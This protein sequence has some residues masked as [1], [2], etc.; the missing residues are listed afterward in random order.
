MESRDLEITN[1]P[2]TKILAVTTVTDIGRPASG[3]VAFSLG[4]GK[5]KG[6]VSGTGWVNFN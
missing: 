4:E 5:F 3:D 2:S 1:T 6:Y